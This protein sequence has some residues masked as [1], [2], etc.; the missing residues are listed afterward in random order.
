[1]GAALLARI[2]E[3]HDL[4]VGIADVCTH[5]EVVDTSEANER[6]PYRTVIG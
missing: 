3:C 1:L 4:D 2:D 6:G 5:V